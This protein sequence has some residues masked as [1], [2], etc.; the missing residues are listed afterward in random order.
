MSFTCIG[1]CSSIVGTSK[2]I[3][4]ACR[5]GWLSALWSCEES[6]ILTT[7][8]TPFGQYRWLKLPFELSVSNY[9]YQKHLKGLTCV[10]NGIVA[11]GKGHNEESAQK[12]QD[13][14]L[15]NL[16]QRCRNLK[17]Q[18]NECKIALSS[19]EAT[20]RSRSSPVD[21]LQLTWTRLMKFWRCLH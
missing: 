14:K 3:L 11:Y 17:I 5:K 21:L 2:T 10:A 15:E 18:L 7:F 19:H 8:Q 12:D 16:L 9:M 1:W 4:K 20:S 6:S 13:W